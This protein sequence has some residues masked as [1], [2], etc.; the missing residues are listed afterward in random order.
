MYLT[1]VKYTGIT[2]VTTGIGVMSILMLPL[3]T[4]RG[5]HSALFAI[6]F[7]PPKLKVSSS[8]K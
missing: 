3:E 8:T 7:I 2:S 5:L 6:L 4:H 1:Y